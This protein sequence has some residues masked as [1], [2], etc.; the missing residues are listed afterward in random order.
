MKGFLVA[1][2]NLILKKMVVVVVVAVV[3]VCVSCGVTLGKRTLVSCHRIT[4]PF[5]GDL[6]QWETG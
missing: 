1:F 2:V 5:L 4:Y 3:S 6:G